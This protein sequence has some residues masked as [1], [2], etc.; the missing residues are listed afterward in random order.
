M[1]L[2]NNII[3]EKLLLSNYVRK[4]LRDK[5]M[6]FGKWQVVCIYNAIKRVD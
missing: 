4:K 6:C 5:R 3:L 2:F 1:G